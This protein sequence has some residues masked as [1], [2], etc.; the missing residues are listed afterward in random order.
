HTHGSR[1]LELLD[2][3]GLGFAEWA[4]KF[5]KG[6]YF[7]LPLT[8]TNFFMV[9]SLSAAFPFV[10]I[11]GQSVLPLANGF[12]F[13]ALALT[14]AFLTFFTGGT[15]FVGDAFTFA[16]LAGVPACVRAS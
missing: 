15:P 10:F 12:G 13:K 4:L 1:V 5:K 7:F 11:P 14:T 9:T 2:D 8:F 16:F 3:F 6:H